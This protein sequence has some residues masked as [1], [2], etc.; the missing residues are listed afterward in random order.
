MLH[1]HF[2]LRHRILDPASARYYD[3]TYNEKRLWSARLLSQFLLEDAILISIDESNFRSS[4]HSK[5][6]WT[7]VP[8]KV[9]VRN[10]LRGEP[11]TESKFPLNDDNDSDIPVN[12]AELNGESMSEQRNTKVPK[13]CSIEMIRPKRK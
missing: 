6:K 11:I 13:R 1:N 12:D 9:N 5:G 8:G 4:S 3:P 2:H 10:L 7:F